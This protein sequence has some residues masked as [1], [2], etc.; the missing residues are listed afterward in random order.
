MNIPPR[1]LSTVAALL[2][3]AA[4]TVHAQPY[5]SKPVRLVVPF[6]AGG[7]TDITARI[8]S[9]KV[10]EALGHNLIIDNRGGASSIIARIS[11]PNRRP[12][13]TRC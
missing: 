13:A 9:P 4:T 1:A 6:P 8:I 12:T 3:A 11:S 7:P 2:L 10:S 5:P